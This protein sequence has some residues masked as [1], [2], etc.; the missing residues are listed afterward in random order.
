MQKKDYKFIMM[1]LQGIIDRL[2][3]FPL[4]EAKWLQNKGEFPAFIPS[5]SGF[6]NRISSEQEDTQQVTK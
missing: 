2:R 4:L 5:F 6:K 1:P 3:L